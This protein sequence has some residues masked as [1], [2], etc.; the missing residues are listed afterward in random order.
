MRKSM[1]A[2]SPEAFMKTWMPAGAP[3]MEAMQNFMKQA[4]AAG[5][6]FGAGG[7]GPNDDDK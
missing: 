1:E 7:K 5:A 2:M 6:G 4:M 3:G